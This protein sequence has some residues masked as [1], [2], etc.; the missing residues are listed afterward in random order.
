MWFGVI[1]VPKFKRKTFIISFG[2][3]DELPEFDIYSTS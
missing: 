2:D 1:F 3:N